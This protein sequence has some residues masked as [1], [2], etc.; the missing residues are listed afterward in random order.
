[1]WCQRTYPFKFH[2]DVI[3]TRSEW[4][5]SL[6]TRWPGRLWLYHYNL[7][8]FSDPP[9]LQFVP[10]DMSTGQQVWGDWRLMWSWSCFTQLEGCGRRILLI[11]SHM[12]DCT[13]RFS[14]DLIG[15]PTWYLCQK[16]CKTYTVYPSKYQTIAIL[17]WNVF[18]TACINWDLGSQWLLSSLVRLEETIPKPSVTLSESAQPSWIHLG[19]MAHGRTPNQLGRWLSQSSHR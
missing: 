19:P 18:A 4:A 10:G 3:A 9:T 2:Q 15:T 14:V 8:L 7:V 5:L 16:N 12:M 6:C 17:L 1:M 11:S 13:T